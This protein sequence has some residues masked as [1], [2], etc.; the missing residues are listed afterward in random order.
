M[1]NAKSVDDFTSL[2]VANNPLH[3]SFMKASLASMREDTHSE[4]TDYLKYCLSIGL[5]L[6]YLADSYNTIV[7][8]TLMEQMFFAENK[9]YRWSRFDELAHA[10]Y[11]DDTYM[12]KYMYGLA[13]TAFLWPNHVALHDFFVRT[14]PRGQ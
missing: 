4:L 2:V 8:D 1:S 12:R 3:S 6:E 7:N 13:I 14:F 9:R 5:S 11:F 10:V